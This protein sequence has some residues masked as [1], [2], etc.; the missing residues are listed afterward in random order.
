MLVY[1]E[2]LLQLLRESIALGVSVGLFYCALSALRI[3][4]CEKR[5]TPFRKR[6][7]R[8]KFPLIGNPYPMQTKHKEAP[9]FTK[10]VIIL[11]DVLFCI[12]TA[13]GIL[14]LAFVGNYGRI[15]WFLLLGVLF[16]FLLTRFLFFKRAINLFDIIFS[17][18]RL[19]FCYLFQIFTLPIRLGISLIVLGAR[20]LISC[21]LR[22]AVARKEAVYRKKYTKRIQKLAS[23]GFGVLETGI[24]PTQENV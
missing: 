3:L 6:L 23:N 10:A 13:V 24:L 15:R 20:C 17:I 11:L 4:L 19:L 5:E 14:L 18:C 8:I 1:P 16:G 22:L 2:L 21:T 7:A 9:F 12:T